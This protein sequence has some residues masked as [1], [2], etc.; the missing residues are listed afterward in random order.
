MTRR[1]EHRQAGEDYNSPKYHTS[2]YKVQ[3]QKWE[4]KDVKQKISNWDKSFLSWKRKTIK[5][6]LTKCRPILNT[7][8]SLR[9]I[10]PLAQE[11]N[12][13]EAMDCD[14]QHICNI[15]STYSMHQHIIPASGSA[16]SSTSWNKNIQ[17]FISRRR[18]AIQEK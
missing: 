18:H 16:G 2:K 4:M 5:T 1:L 11:D 3:F 6:K 12:R 14:R 9:Y 8:G 10:R 15:S 13:K 7:K 17:I